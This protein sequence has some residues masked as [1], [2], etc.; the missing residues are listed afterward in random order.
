MV[1]IERLKK[2]ISRK[3]SIKEQQ[4]KVKIEDWGAALCKPSNIY[5]DMEL[6]EILNY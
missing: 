1:R 4:L 6:R 3:K 2:S 5:N